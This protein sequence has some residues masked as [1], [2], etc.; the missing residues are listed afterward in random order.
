MS[1]RGTE[2]ATG[3]MPHAGAPTRPSQTTAAHTYDVALAGGT[4]TQDVVGGVTVNSLTWSGGTLAGIN[5]LTVLNKV[6]WTDGS[7]AE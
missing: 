6:T 7:L 4:V 5:P 1:R 3:P 2:P